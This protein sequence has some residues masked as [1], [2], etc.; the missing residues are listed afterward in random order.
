MEAAHLC[1][2]RVMGHHHQ[3]MAQHSS[4]TRSQTTTLHS[5]SVTQQKSLPMQA[6]SY[7]QRST[8]HITLKVL[9]GQYGTSQAASPRNE[10]TTQP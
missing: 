1:T 9:C 5:S 3:T 4:A 6:T 10:G 7:I 8:P 2:Q